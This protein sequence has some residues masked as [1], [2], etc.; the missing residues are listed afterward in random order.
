MKKI[1]SISVFGDNP[2]YT[3]GALKNIQLSKEFYP[4][5]DIYLYYNITVP[6]DIVNM[7][8][9]FDH[10]TLLDMTN[11]NIPGMFWRFLPRNC[12]RFISRDADSR[13]SEREALAVDEWIKS[14]KTL[15]VM[16]DHP[17]HDGAPIYGGLFGIV[18]K[19][20]FIIEDEI[21]KWIIGKDNSLFNRWGDVLFCNQIIYE[22]YKNEG[23]MISH[24][25]VWNDY[26]YS[27]PFPKPMENYRFIG[28]IFDENDNRYP[29][30]TEW[31]SKNELR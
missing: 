8:K 17:H 31:I 23:D 24:D 28:E 12:E 30:Y 5:W 19:D 27:K 13:L 11:Y 18:I 1:I 14:E 9:E 2:K 25:S 16:R 29:Q 7:Y 21:N 10:V 22:K 15:H 3:I 4:D 6:I 20:D 26:P